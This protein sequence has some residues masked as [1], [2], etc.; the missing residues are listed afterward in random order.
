MC[1]AITYRTKNHYFGRNLDY[2]ISYGENVVITPRNYS[3]SFRK[4]NE[5]T[6]HFALIGMGIVVNNYPLYYEA[7][8]EKGL[9]MA[10]LLF[11]KNCKYKPE[12]EG[13]DNITPFELIPWILGQCA[14]VAEAKTK[15]ERINV[16]EIPFDENYPLSPLHWMISDREASITV[17]CVEEG[18]RVYENPMGV[19]ANDPTFD[20]HLLA[21]EKHQE[22]PGDLSSP[23]RFLRATSTKYKSVSGEEEGE[24]VSQFFHILGSVEQVKGN[25]RK[26]ENAYE[27]TIYS[28]CCNTDRGI[29]YYITY[30]NRQITA[31]DMHQEDL[32]ASSLYSYPLI[33]TQQ[34]KYQNGE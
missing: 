1:T 33:R 11:K 29:Y 5:I 28:C 24:S 12:T 14:N 6:T 18:L 7:T 13:K 20:K 3:F 8:N 19:L 9:S 4:E 17:E 23:S 16:V 2:D 10:G 25:G 21:W 15:L 32:D 26:G 31:V 22:I 30:D 34:I 27:H